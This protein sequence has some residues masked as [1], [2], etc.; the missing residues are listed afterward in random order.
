MTDLPEYMTIYQI[1]LAMPWISASMLRAWIYRKPDFCAKCVRRFGKKILIR[2][3]E[4]S[5]WIDTQPSYLK[6]PKISMPIG[7]LNE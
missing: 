3:A 1:T 7:G 4:L 2:P 5:K 6:R